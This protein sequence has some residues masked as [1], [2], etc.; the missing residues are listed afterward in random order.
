MKKNPV[1]AI[2][3]GRIMTVKTALKIWKKVDNA[4]DS[5]I[6]WYLGSDVDARILFFKQYRDFDGHGLTKPERRLQLKLERLKTEKG[7]FVSWESWL[8]D[9]FCFGNMSED[10]QEKIKR[11]KK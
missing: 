1:R 10:F 2:I 9:V 4:E 7:K 11:L 8:H 5:K 3:F 6:R